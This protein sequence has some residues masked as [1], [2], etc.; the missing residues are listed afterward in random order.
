M[1]SFKKIHEKAAAQLSETDIKK[2]ASLDY[3]SLYDDD[4]GPTEEEKMQMQE[5]AEKAACYQKRMRFQQHMI[6]LLA[7]TTALAFAGIVLYS[8]HQYQNKT[9]ITTAAAAGTAAASE[10]VT[11]TQPQSQSAASSSVSILSS[12]DSSSGISHGDY[13]I[14]NPNAPYRKVNETVTSS[15]DNVNLRTLPSTE[16]GS[17][18]IANIKKGQIVTRT[19][20]GENGWSELSYHGKTVYAV[21]DLIAVY[22]DSA[23]AAN[24]SSVLTW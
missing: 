5:E 4:P 3:A 20:V 6:R 9:E 16:N 12:A 22:E 14:Y 1:K 10:S 8:F 17:I 15:G 21:T 13:H 18:I 19:A 11:V 24:T 23:S 2:D 7:V